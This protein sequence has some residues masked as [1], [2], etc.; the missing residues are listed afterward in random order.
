MSVSLQHCTYV[1]IYKGEFESGFHKNGQTKEHALLA[2]ALGIQ[3]IIILV[4]KM[5][6][7][8]YD[9]NRYNHIETLI[10]KY[11]LAI[12]FKQKSFA[13]CVYVC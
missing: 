3:K 6:C 8:D 2:F 11:L 12:G 1:K 5:D 7:V 10:I 4:N 13:Q 9:Q